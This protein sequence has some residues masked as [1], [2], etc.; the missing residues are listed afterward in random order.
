MKNSIIIAAV[1]LLIGFGLGSQLFPKIKEK[2]VEVEVEKVVKDIVTVTK[3]ITRPDGTKEELTTVTDKTKE[4][5][6]ATSVKILSKPDW[7]ISA[8]GTVIGNSTYGIQIERRVLGDVF[9]G[10]GYNTDNKINVS[11]GIEF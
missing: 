6:E 3:V 7:H 10:A 1:A 8:N 9:V 5:R 4:N 2:T 11:V